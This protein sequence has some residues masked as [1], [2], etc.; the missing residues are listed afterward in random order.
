MALL[1]RS[2]LM[3]S[4]AKLGCINYFKILLPCNRNLFHGVSRNATT[5]STK[6]KSPKMTH[7]EV[8][9][10]VPT[11]VLLYS[12]T[13]DRFFR[14][15]TIFGASQFLFW[16]YMSNFAYSSLRD[17]SSSKEGNESN[18]AD[19]N[20]KVVETD[21][22]TVA[23]WKNI[24][25]GENK[26]RTG[27]TMLCTALGYTILFGSLF[28]PLRTIHTL[29]LLKGGQAVRITTYGA[30]ARKRPFIK[31]LAEISCYVAR[32]SAT[33]AVPLK[34]KG[35]TFFYL[36]DVKKGAFH[37]TKLFDSTVGL[38]RKFTR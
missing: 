14:L 11:D 12:Y 16:M 37:N 32:Q 35:R 31:D 23:W 27:L 20:Q 6:S 38:K 22:N 26:I 18:D 15:L 10:N 4:V 19:T 2:S 25:L 3:H 9:A 36:M 13:N 30:L 21:G 7:F 33:A 1:L 8:D 28:Y 17:I 34:V 24:N 5:T 29:H